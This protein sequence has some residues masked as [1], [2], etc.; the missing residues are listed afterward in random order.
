MHIL[1]SGKHDRYALYSDRGHKEFTPLPI[2]TM[3]ETTVACPK[4]G[5]PVPLTEALAAPLIEATKAEY[6]SRLQEQGS[7]LRLRT[8]QFEEQERSTAKK[9]EALTLREAALHRMEESSRAEL[10]AKQAGIETEIARQVAAGLNDQLPELLAIEK[11]RIS[12]VEQRRATVLFQDELAERNRDR[13]AQEE[14]ISQLVSRLT[15]AQAAEAELMRRERQ[16]QDRERELQLQIEQEVS[17]Q[18]D[19]VRATA[20]HQAH[21][22]WSL[23]LTDKDRQIQ[24]LANQLK[25]A[26]R[27]AE[28]GS[29]QSQGETLELV[30]EE[31]LR[32][33]FPSDE[34]RPVPKGEFGGDTL[35]VVRDSSGREAGRILW[36][37]KRTK[38]WSAAWITK[39][40]GDQR[41]AKADLAVIVSQAMPLDVQHFN[42]VDGIWVSSFGCTLPVA[43]ALR[44][45]LIQLAGQRRAAEGQQSKSEL[46][47]G[48]LIGSQFRG[49]IE[50]I[51][52]RWTEMQKDLVAEKKAT[53]TRWAKREA[54]LQTLLASTTGIFGDLQG[55]AG[56]D[57]GEINALGD[58]LL[59]TSES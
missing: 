17:G 14:R 56:R 42:E 6:E 58:T 43:T 3:L 18:L 26:S 5:T 32:R 25:E 41:T 53:L 30:L 29:Q 33:Q 10:A 12:E 46:I 11:K 50:A 27:K 39:L 20:S 45:S 44:A 22:R 16:F 35:Q 59:L 28:Q 24:E 15:A 51:A 19:Q 38:T 34:L 1:N 40:K 31:Q 13:I 57:M 23:Q 55:I 36:E 4:C 49:R 21:E 9:S 48:Y 52:E 47:Y 2:A 37:Y 7:E 54:Q 8:E